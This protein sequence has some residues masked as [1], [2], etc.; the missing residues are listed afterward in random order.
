[1]KHIKSAFLIVVSLCAI[2]IV[3]LFFISCCIA[4]CTSL[5][6]SESRALVASSSSRIGACL[7]NARAI[8]ILCFCPPEILA[9]FWPIFVAYWSGR[10]MMKS[11]A[12]AAFAACSISSCVASN[13]LY[14]MLLYIVSLNRPAS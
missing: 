4:F 11:W 9:P 1:M 12:E 2:M 7:R 13:L 10:F 14:L 5:S 8:A 3:V 6:D